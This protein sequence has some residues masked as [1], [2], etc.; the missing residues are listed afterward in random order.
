MKHATVDAVRLVYRDQGDGL[1]VLLVHGFPLDHT[2]WL[3]VV[4]RLAGRGRFLMPDLRGYGASEL[5]DGAPGWD[6]ESGVPMTRYAD[7]LAAVLD[8]AAV[9]GPV[10]Y[11]GFSMGGYI[12]W[13]FARRYPDRLRGLAVID[14]RAG[15]DT[16]EAR[17]MRLKMARHVDEWGAAH[18][19]TAMLPKLFAPESLA[20]GLP[21]VAQTRSLIAGA[22]T[23]AIAA[24]QR[25]MAGRPDETAMLANLPAP[26][27]FLGGEHDQLT[28]PEEMRAMASAAGGELTLVPGAGHM[29]P[30][31]NPAAVAEV[32]GRFIHQLA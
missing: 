26:A 18:V 16:P 21:A 17:E 8:D 9:S 19:A 2:M 4:E 31:E 32:L 23:A 7:D 15:A 14:S 10:L 20:A 1:P 13:Q 30:V 12:G 5:G 11:V 6:A 25:G 3:P 29:A 27:V 24:A 28:T 22:D